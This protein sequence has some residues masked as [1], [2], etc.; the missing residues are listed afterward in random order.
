MVGVEQ[1]RAITEACRRLR[2]IWA[3]R[4]DRDREL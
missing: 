4:H 2:A 1:L 3:L